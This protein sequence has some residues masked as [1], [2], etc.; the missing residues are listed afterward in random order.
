[1]KNSIFISIGGCSEPPGVVTRGGYS[2]YLRRFGAH[3][4]ARF[5]A[6]MLVLLLKEAIWARC[7][8]RYSKVLEWFVF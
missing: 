5:R 7:R 1:M 6:C 2:G 4:R 8:I 3:T